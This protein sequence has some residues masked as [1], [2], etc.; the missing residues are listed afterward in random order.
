MLLGRY[1]HVVMSIE[2]PAN[3]LSSLSLRQP[4]KPA[5]RT[6]S[7]VKRTIDIEIHLV[8]PGRGQF[9]NCREVGRGRGRESMDFYTYLSR[10]SFDRAKEFFTLAVSIVISNVFS[11]IFTFFFA[12][13][14]NQGIEFVV[15]VGTLLGAMNGALIGKETESGFIRG[16]AV[17][18]ISGAVFSLEVLESSLLSDESLTGCLQYLIDVIA[19]LLSGRLVRE[20]LGPAIQSVMQKHV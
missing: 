6:L 18:A 13:V 14:T 15:A 1:Q 4:P 19:S 12:V 8:I 16:A 17:G 10:L 3:H 11:F 7:E 9:L 20:R 5:P 2:K